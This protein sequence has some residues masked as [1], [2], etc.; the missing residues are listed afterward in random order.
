MRTAF[1]GSSGLTRQSGHVLH[2]NTFCKGSLESLKAY[3]DGRP[4][5]ITPLPAGRGFACVGGVPLFSNPNLYHPSGM[6]MYTGGSVAQLSS[7]MHSLHKERFPVL[8]HR[9]TSL[10]L[11]M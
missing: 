1:K 7:S 10:T 11:V 4:H 2:R 8:I 3:H 6:F 9:R 5:A